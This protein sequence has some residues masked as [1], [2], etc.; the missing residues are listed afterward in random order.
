[1][2]D[3]NLASFKHIAQIKVFRLSFRVCVPRSTW[4]LGF[5][6]VVKRGQSA[7]SQWKGRGHLMPAGRE[8]VWP[9]SSPSVCALLVLYGWPPGYNKAN[10]RPLQAPRARPGTA[11][12]FILPLRPL[13]PLDIHLPPSV[14]MRNSQMY[15]YAPSRVDGL[16]KTIPP[17]R[18]N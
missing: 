5:S 13:H 1:M 9:Y 10:S 11:A 15:L 16:I 8:N 3:N 4:N 12:C 14:R 7:Y 17:R 18:R 6:T 2:V